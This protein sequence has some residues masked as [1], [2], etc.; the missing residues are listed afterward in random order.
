MVYIY[1]VSDTRS[2][3]ASKTDAAG[4]RLAATD[5]LA[6]MERALGQMPVAAQPH[7]MA[8]FTD[9]VIE[10]SETVL[11]RTSKPGVTAGKVLGKSAGAGGGSFVGKKSKKRA[12]ALRKAA[13][14]RLVTKSAP[15]VQCLVCG[16][17]N[18]PGNNLCANCVEP[19]PGMVIPPLSDLASPHVNK[20]AFAER[21]W[22]GMY[23]NSPD[24]ALR[25]MVN[26]ARYGGL[27]G[28]AA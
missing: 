21:V 19:M 27:N 17:G 24:P 9:G 4:A 28:G 26:K 18:R 5:L 13:A 22:G 23:G 8:V 15:T 12:R 16:F 2:S 20:A 11:T 1:G 14:R 3:G 10:A 6:A 7:F 25:E